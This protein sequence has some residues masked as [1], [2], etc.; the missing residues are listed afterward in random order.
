MAASVASRFAGKALL[1]FL[2]T[3]SST[4]SGSVA[5]SVASKL[6]SLEGATGLIG[7]AA[8][9]PET[10]GKLIGSA[11]GPLTIAG[12]AA[13]TGALVNY[14]QQSRH[15]LPVQAN[16]ETMR[17]PAFASQQYIPGVSPLTNAQMGESL[18]DQQR[19]QHQLDL[20][21]ARQQASTGAGTLSAGSNV[22]DIIGLAQKIYG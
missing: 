19:Y 21:Q 13:G 10:T 2:K 20:I 4:V 5:K 7:L 14:L 17:T 6:G 9:Y 1:D 18:L 16:A 15:S 11:A 3:A 22:S 12:A 8:K